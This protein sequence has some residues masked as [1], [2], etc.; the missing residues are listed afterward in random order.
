MI[1]NKKNSFYTGKKLKGPVAYSKQ[2]HN[3]DPFQGRI[4]FLATG[5]AVSKQ[6]QVS[7]PSKFSSTVKR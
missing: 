1:A 2:I 7:T 4:C 6:S 5:S 3:T